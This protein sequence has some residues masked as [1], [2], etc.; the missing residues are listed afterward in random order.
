VTWQAILLSCLLLAGCAT[1]PEPAL[2]TAPSSLKRDRHP[3]KPPRLKARPLGRRLLQLA[4]T[5][6]GRPYR[7]GGDHPE[8]GFDCSG[9][10]FYLYRRLG[11]PVPRT[12][13]EQF[14]KAH[15][16]EVPRPGDLLF[17]RVGKGW[18]VGIYEGGGNFIHAPTSGGRVRRERLNHF[19]RRRFIGAGY[20]K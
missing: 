11:V 20:L 4:R 18:H 8:E 10:V 16:V 5:Q 9:L 6:L 7:Y 15:K 13:K 12:A 3:A 2:E 1:P 19:W 14:L 17:F